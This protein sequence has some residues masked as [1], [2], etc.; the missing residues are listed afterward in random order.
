MSSFGTNRAV[1]WD[2]CATWSEAA[3]LAG[4]AQRL[5]GM[6]VRMRSIGQDAL[7]PHIACAAAR[8]PGGDES[9]ATYLVSVSY[10]TQ[11]QAAGSVQHML[12]AVV[13]GC[14]LHS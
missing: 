8:D 6:E 11:A 9:L 1:T 5:A 2:Y 7:G 3:D 14:R 12:E 13:T 10:D 4:V